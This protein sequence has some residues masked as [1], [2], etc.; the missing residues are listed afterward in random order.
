M[1]K[2]SLIAVILML[3]LLLSGCGGA[4]GLGKMGSGL[5]TVE[6]ISSLDGRTPVDVP[7]YSDIEYIRPDLAILR[8]ETAHLKRAINE[9][10][11]LNKIMTILDR[12]Y[13]EYYN[14]ITMY[15]ITDLES[16]RD[17]TDSYWA[18]EFNWLDT[19][20]Y[21]LQ[22][23]MEDIYY[24]CGESEMA[25]RLEK[26]YFWDGFAEEYAQ[27]ESES[28][29][30]ERLMELYDRESSLL[31]EYRGL[32]AEPVIEVNGRE[33]SLNEYILTADDREYDWAMEEYYKKYNPLLSEI[34]IELIKVRAEIAEE[35]GYD[36]Y[37]QMQ[38]EYYFER[39]YG[40]EEAT[41]Y[42][43]DIKRCMVPLYKE[44]LGD[45][46]YGEVFFDDISRERLL[47][48]IAEG[49]SNIGGQVQ[50]A[51]IF[52]RRY[53][54]YD[55]EVSG[56]KAPMS[57]Q[58]YLSSYEAPYIFLDAV[59]DIE[60]ILSFAHEFGHYVEAYVNYDSYASIDVSECYSQAMEYL[61]LGSVEENMS[62]RELDNLYRL[63]MVD[64][65]D[66]YVQQASFAEFEHL[67]YSVPPEE[68]DA[69]YLNELSLQLAI[70]YGYYDGESELYY[71]MSWM[72]IPHFF[73]YPFYVISYPVSNDVA[74]QIYELELGRDGAGVERYLDMLPR[75]HS[76]LIDT[77]ESAGFESPFAPGRIE[78]VAELMRQRFSGR[79]A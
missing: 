7:H 56:D 37:E 29:Y 33:V 1:K 34:Y 49:A 54:Y 15:T 31:A 38:Y 9:G 68:L 23:C 28:L 71:A 8:A 39:D 24:I 12:C 67:V 77:V 76:G 45:D 70:D 74:M 64:T 65:L 14:F 59:G 36:S 2:R 19:A 20:Y 60:D 26:A 72:D 53:G 25:E 55:I 52:M 61:L 73:E 6:R 78:K 57:F 50:E 79:A 32:I 41:A 18:A 43:R 51:Y 13:S 48:I 35:L 69:D 5:I 44:F 47:N 62:P 22:E 58:T 11:S 4:S 3:A 21:E 27:R 75:E 16:C 40:P 63:K 42:I 66:L 17:V 46:P 30:S 10:Q